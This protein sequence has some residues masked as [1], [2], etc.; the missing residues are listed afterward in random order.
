MNPADPRASLLPNLSQ[1][2]VDFVIPM[3]IDLPLGI[4]PFLLLEE[5]G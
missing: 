2:Q 3:R 5:S 4:D 1:Y